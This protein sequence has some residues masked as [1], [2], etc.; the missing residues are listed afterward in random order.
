MGSS[1]RLTLNGSG[2]REL[3]S[4]TKWTLTNYSDKCGT[5]AENIFACFTKTQKANKSNL[6]KEMKLATFTTDIMVKF[7]KFALSL[8]QLVLC[9]PKSRR[10]EKA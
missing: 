2:Q 5:S 9:Q 6:S 4:M 10:R 8:T 7:T 1:N 3:S